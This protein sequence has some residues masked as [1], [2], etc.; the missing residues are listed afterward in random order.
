[1]LFLPMFSVGDHLSALAARGFACNP[2]KAFMSAQY[3]QSCCTNMLIFCNVEISILA[4]MEGFIMCLDA[5]WSHQE[6]QEKP[7][8]M[9]ISNGLFTDRILSNSEKLLLV[10]LIEEASGDPVEY[11]FYFFHSLY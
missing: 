8:L 3:M 7:D 5:L 2:C 11:A 10:A 6:L 4:M 9:M 1:M